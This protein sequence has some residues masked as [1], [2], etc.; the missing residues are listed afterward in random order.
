MGAFG[1]CSY[2]SSD[3][4]E[5][6]EDNQDARGVLAS[7]MV[8]GCLVEEA[9][10]LFE[11]APPVRSAILEDPYPCNNARDPL[12]V[13]PCR[14]YCVS[15]VG[16]IG[17]EECTGFSDHVKPYVC[18]APSAFCEGLPIPLSKS[19]VCLV[20]GSNTP[21]LIERGACREVSSSFDI[22][23]HPPVRI[24]SPQHLHSDRRGY[25][26]DGH[27]TRIAGGADSRRTRC[28]GV[29]NRPIRWALVMPLQTKHGLDRFDGH[30]PADKVWPLAAR[31]RPLVDLPPRREPTSL[32]TS[33]CPAGGPMGPDTVAVMDPN[34]LAAIVAAAAAILSV[35][36]SIVFGALNA[37]SANRSAVAAEEAQRLAGRQLEAGVSATEQA[38]QPYLWADLR[39]RA[40]GSLLVLHIGNSGPTVATRVRVLFEPPL[41]DLAEEERRDRMTA[42]GAALASGLTSLAPGRSCGGPW[43]APVFS[44][45]L[46][47][48]RRRCE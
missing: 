5:L 1:R 7:E 21:Q 16:V 8:A 37:R 34:A 31:R 26:R 13:E 24:E 23:L 4:L 12:V 33:A 40:D 35:L 22:S 10:A 19:D 17:V 44:Y 38:L 39:P 25:R 11:R 2:L 36:V 42:T 3:A 27:E 9:L 15:P 48:L 32:A 41:A 14:N 47:S 43:A 46:T 20:L 6:G 28:D 29:G 18:D 30:L 45:P